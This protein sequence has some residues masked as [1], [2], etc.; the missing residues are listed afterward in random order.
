MK[1]CIACDEADEALRQIAKKANRRHR[2]G[3]PI[4]LTEIE[5]G[6]AAR[7]KHRRDCP[8]RLAA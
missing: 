4:D 6:R 8:I 7:D 3:L 1:H 2:L 5:K